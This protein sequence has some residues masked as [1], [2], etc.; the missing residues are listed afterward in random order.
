MHAGY[1]KYREALLD[2]GIGIYELKSDQDSAN[3]RDMFNR[4]DLIGS[5][6]ASL[7]A[8][9]FVIDDNRLFVGSFDFDPRST[10]LNTEI[11]FLIHSPKMAQQMAVELDRMI[12]AS[13]YYVTLTTEGDK[14]W[15]EYTDGGTK[16][17]HDVEPKTTWI[18]RTAVTVIGWL[19]VMWM[20]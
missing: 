8:K 15:T 2:S 4:F 18:T 6:T 3:L 9:T 5:S 12:K 20:L 14:L 19:P 16:K 13:A 1:L 11:G 10:N 7:H 17:M